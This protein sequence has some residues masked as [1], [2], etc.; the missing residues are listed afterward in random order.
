MGVLRVSK[1]L[2]RFTE[3][4]GKSCEK[5][6]ALHIVPNFLRGFQ[7]TIH[8]LR[9]R[10]HIDL[11]PGRDSILALPEARDRLLLRVK[12]DTGLSIESVRTTTRN[13]RLVTR[14]AEHGERDGDGDI[15][16]DLSGLDF[17][18]EFSG[19]GTGRGEDCSSV[20]VF[21]V[22]Y[23]SD[24]VVD[25]LYVEADED[26]SEDLLFVTS[27]VFCHV[28]DDGWADLGGVLVMLCV[29]NEM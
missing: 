16:P 27:H 2:A 23:E 3:G 6:S 28:G 26:R 14:E 12:V 13:T 22:V 10:R 8:F 7:H 15:D 17:F 21:V 1:G 19:S 4:S 20:A 25:G 11:C 9:L 29:M 24:G 18:L 5:S